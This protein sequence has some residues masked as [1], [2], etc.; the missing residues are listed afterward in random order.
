MG[1]NLIIK[2][3]DFSQ[4]AID[5]SSYL[6][7][8]VVQGYMT[9]IPSSQT[10]KQIETNGSKS[11]Y[12]IVTKI[13]VP[14]GRKLSVFIENNGSRITDL[15]SNFLSSTDNIELVDGNAV[16]NISEAVTTDVTDSYRQSDGSFLFNNTSDTNLYYYINFGYSLSGPEFNVSGKNCYYTIL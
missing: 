7:S 13:T 8:S 15:K 12:F 9:V 5:G 14:A 6:E 2:G 3:A 1:K 4:N 10:Y 16:E 11:I